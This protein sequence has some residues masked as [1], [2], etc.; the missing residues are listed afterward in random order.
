MTKTI[1]GCAVLAV[2]VAIAWFARGLIRNSLQPPTPAEP[3]LAFIPYGTPERGRDADVL[4]LQKQF[5]SAELLKWLD[6]NQGGGIVGFYWTRDLTAKY[7]H[8]WYDHGAKT[9]LA[10][11]Q[12]WTTALAIELPNDKAQRKYFFD[13][14]AAFPHSGGGIPTGAMPGGLSREFAAAEH[15]Q[16]DVDQKYLLLEF[17]T[18]K[19]AQQFGLPQGAQQ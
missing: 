14:A 1:L 15:R 17:M 8:Q 13:F 12:T 3:P 4:D 2:L 10:F 11:G 5:G 7:A 6:T 19:Q 9:V 16:T 18:Q